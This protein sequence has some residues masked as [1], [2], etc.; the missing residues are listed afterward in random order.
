MAPRL[1]VPAARV[2]APQGSR[3]LAQAASKDVQLPPQHSIAGRYASALYMAAVKANKLTA[4]EGELVQVADLMSRSKEFSTFVNDPTIPSGPKTDGL[5]AVLS[6]INASDITKYVVGARSHPHARGRAARAHRAGLR[7]N[8]P[9]AVPWSD[10][11]ACYPRCVGLLA[12]N[13]RLRELTKILE[14]FGE[15]SAEQKGQV[16]AMVTTAEVSPRS[17][18]W[19][20][21]GRWLQPSSPSSAAAER[22]APPRPTLSA[23][24]GLTRA[25][26]QEIQSGLK[27]LLKPG[28]SLALQERIDPSIIG[29]VVVDIG[30]K[31]VDF[32]ILSRVRKLQNIIRDAV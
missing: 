25:E 6:K 14:K 3:G 9:T 28:Q 13:R 31:H 10:R 22:R 29:G 11:R 27:Q 21:L 12:E 4:V 17:R 32:S 5:N 23:A 7:R 30:D 2:P 26:A 1:R 24:Q 18:R 16:S 20:P 8:A 15:I 19:A